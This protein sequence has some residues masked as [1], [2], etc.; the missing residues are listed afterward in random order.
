MSAP[1][2]YKEIVE[3][4][5]EHGA[6]I[7]AKDGTAYKY[8]HS[9]GN[10]EIAELLIEKGANIDQW[11]GQCALMKSAEIGN[12]R[13]FDLLLKKGIY[14]NAAK[15][16]KTEILV[17]LDGN[18]R[19][20]MIAQLLEQKADV[21]AE[22]WDYILIEVVKKRCKKLVKLLLEKGAHV[23]AAGYRDVTPLMIASEYGHQEMV[24][25]LLEKGADVNAKNND[26]EPP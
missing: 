1:C 3:L 23:N 26:G 25:L 20:E 15:Y 17:F 19:W 22:D 2:G 12:K 9:K 13:I 4:L 7:N 14:G 5:L 11:D 18:S 21:S 16:F 8:A 6:D 24:E 10:Q